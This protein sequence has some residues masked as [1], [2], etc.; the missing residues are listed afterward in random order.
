MRSCDRIIFL[1]LGLASARHTPKSGLATEGVVAGSCGWFGHSPTRKTLI[2]ALQRAQ[3]P[4]DCSSARFLL[5]DEFSNQ[6]GLGFS[7]LALHAIL[8][9]SMHENRSLIASSAILGSH[10]WRWCDAGVRDYGCYFEPWS[11]CAAQLRRDLSSGALDESSIPHWDHHAQSLSSRVVRL[12]FKDDVTQASIFKLYGSWMHCIPAIGR[13]WWWSATWDVLLRFVP[14]V[15]QAAQAFLASKGVRM[16]ATTASDALALGQAAAGVAA[17]EEEDG[18][19]RLS[20]APLE[21]PPALRAE[22]FVVVIVRHGGKHV[23]EKLVSVATCLTH[24]TTRLHH[25]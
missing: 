2:A 22:P 25:A 20:A 17:K 3:N 19:T 4:S 9:Q 7:F 6:T 23:E 18:S 16:S 10:P 13:S 12:S 24:C 11:G 14:S 8:L 21:V 1:L 15:E 5:L